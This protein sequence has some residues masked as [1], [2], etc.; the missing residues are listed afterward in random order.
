MGRAKGARVLRAGSGT[1]ARAAASGAFGG[2]AT[3][4]RT[5]RSAA[6][7]AR[8][9]KGAGAAEARTGGPGALGTPWALTRQV[10]AELEGVAYLLVNG[11]SMA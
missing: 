3:A 2:G 8:A 9:K 1:G 7:R 11:V 6:G 4:R 10:P 5:K